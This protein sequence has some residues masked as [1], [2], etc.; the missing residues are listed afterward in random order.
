MTGNELK[1]YAEK[2]GAKMIECKFV[3]FLGTWQHIGYPIERLEDGLENGFGFDGSSIRGWKAINASDMLMIP[4]P[5]SGVMEPFIPTP[6]L[7]LIC[8]VV[9]PITR[10]P[11][12]RC[13]RS[14][15]R[16]AAAYL[17]STGVADQAYFGPEAEFFVFDS[18]RYEE[19]MHTGMFMATSRAS[20]AATSRRTRSTR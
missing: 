20:R 7:S 14:L 3:D 9:D 17:K 16:R 4:D 5:T 19:K 10:E 12:S 2:H 1:S 8:D 13:P 11:Y 6:T 15:A 18:V